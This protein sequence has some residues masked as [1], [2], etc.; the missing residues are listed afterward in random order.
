M[1]PAEHGALADF[2]HRQARA[3]ESKAQECVNVKHDRAAR[4]W[5]VTGRGATLRFKSY[6]LAD[7]EWSRRAGVHKVPNPVLTRRSRP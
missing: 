5:I 2:L 7:A 1:D 4:M 3:A 6:E